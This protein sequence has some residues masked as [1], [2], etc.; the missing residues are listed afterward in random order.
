MSGMFFELV[1]LAAILIDLRDIIVIVTE[2]LG[3]DFQRFSAGIEGFLPLLSV[4]FVNS[5]KVEFQYPHE[6]ILLIL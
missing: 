1:I 3:K 5:R 4:I 6:E 2:M